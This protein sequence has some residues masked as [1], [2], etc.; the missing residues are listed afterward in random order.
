MLTPYQFEKLGKEIFHKHPQLARDNIKDLK[1]YAD[2]QDISKV[3]EIFLAFCQFKNLKPEKITSKRYNSEAQQNKILFTALCLM[4]YKSENLTDLKAPN[5]HGLR[6]QISKVLNI[7]P[8]NASYLTNK[9]RHYF[10]YYKE[11]KEEVETAY[12]HI[13][14]EYVT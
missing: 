2:L 5:R 4:I 12:N 3:N 10:K 14:K 6:L 9:G 8:T 7:I 1:I 11:F 13:M